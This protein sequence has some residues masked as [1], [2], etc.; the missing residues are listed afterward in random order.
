MGFPI[1]ATL[2]KEIYDL[3][4]YYPQPVQKRP[5]IQYIPVPYY[6]NEK[7]QQ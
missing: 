3:M 2:P 7:K 6:E 1:C 5:T 4:D